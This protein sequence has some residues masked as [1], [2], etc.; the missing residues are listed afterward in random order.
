M[1]EQEES[2]CRGNRKH[3]GLPSDQF[4]LFGSALRRWHTR[5]V[6]CAGHPQLCWH[7]W[8]GC[9]MEGFWVQGHVALL[10]PGCILAAAFP[11]VSAKTQPQRSAGSKWLPCRGRRSTLQQLGCVQQLRGSLGT[12]PGAGDCTTLPARAA[13]LGSTRQSFRLA[14]ALRYHRLGTGPSHLPNTW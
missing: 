6:P 11:T 2:A 9:W 13:T 4:H 5:A 12:S 10:V 14:D 7:L 8:A 3:Q 1:G